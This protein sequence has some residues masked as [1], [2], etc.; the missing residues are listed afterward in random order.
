MAVFFS[1]VCARAGQNLCTDNPTEFFTNIA[2][3]LLT[4]ELNLDLARIQIYPTSQYTP[5]VH[6]LLQITVNLYDSTT[7]NLYPTVFRPYFTSDGTNIFINGYELVNGPDTL[8]TSPTFLTIPIDLNDPEA[9]ASI[10]ETP[11]HLNVYG[12]PWIIGARKGFPNLNE[13]VMQSAA[14]ITR[15][16]LIRKPYIITTD[17]TQFQTAQMFLIGISNVLGVEVW[18][19]YSNTYPRPVY[20]QA[21]GTLSMTLTNDLGYNLSL[22][23]PIGGVITGATIVAAGNWQG[24]GW[25]PGVMAPPNPQSF[26]VP[27]LT[28]VVFLPDSAYQLIPLPGQFIP[29]P[30]NNAQDWSLNPPGSFPQPQWGL[31]ITNRIRCMI[32]DGG[33]PGRV[34]DY[35]QLSGLN[36][37]RDLAGEIY[38]SSLSVTNVWITNLVST[39]WGNGTA[40]QGVNNQIYISMGMPD[41]GDSFWANN[42]LSPPIGPTRQWA[43]DYFRAFLGFQPLWNSGLQNTQLVMQVP[44]TPTS[45]KYQLL[46]WQANDPLVHY[47]LGDLTYAATNTLFTVTPPNA[48]FLPAASNLWRYADRY[49]PWGGNP[50]RGPVGNKSA[51]LTSL[52]DPLVRSSDEWD[53]PSGEPLSFGTLG[54]IHRGTP[55]QTVYL[56]ASDIDLSTWINWTG[57]F[58]NWVLAGVG[59]VADAAFSRPVMDR[60]LIDLLG[61]MLSTNNPCRRLSINN[62]DI[63]AWLAVLNGMPVQTNSSPVATLIVSS[64][65]LQ[66]LLIAQGINDARLNLFTNH[67]FLHLGDILATPQLSEQSPFLNTAYLQTLSA[68]GLSD[69][70]MECIPSQLLPLL[71]EDSW[72]LMTWSNTQLRVQ[73]TGYD[74]CAYAVQASSNLKD[75]RDVG[76]YCP[77]NGVFSFPVSAPPGIRRQ[78]YR[79]VLLHRTMD[80]FHPSPAV[81]TAGR[82]RREGVGPYN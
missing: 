31:N 63:N 41:L 23:Y 12:V 46:T 38:S 59:D 68:G 8:P 77:A 43:I 14:Q 22:S 42:M 62:S 69:E 34:I 71:R 1:A 4:S 20:V 37:Y 36:S 72:G 39:F 54:R 26:L 45:K 80:C 3:R 24:T 52:K 70:M 25:Q 57:D 7:N 40:P 78:F 30:T 53:F 82:E 19:S 61:P 51:Y 44:F 79:S 28:N 6:R 15:K 2:S 73:F 50:A 76:T 5:A 48:A 13:I 33:V 66:A 16:L 58:V 32:L 35:V 60:D 74:G 17:F 27:L 10:G 65:S 81:F 21:D 18:N 64:N 49:D 75:W 56:K 11:T 55:W 29:L 47:S 9:R 67:I